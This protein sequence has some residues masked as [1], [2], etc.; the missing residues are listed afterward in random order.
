MKI[1]KRWLI[2]VCLLLV[3]AGLAFAEQDKGAADI[4]LEGGRTGDVPFPHHQH[5]QALKDCDICHQSFAQ[6][7]GAIQKAIADGELKEKQV[8][9]KQCVKCHREKKKAGEKGG[10]ISCS[11]CHSKKK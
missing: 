9:N 6:E 2:L 4:V 8:M 1:G 11:K 7:S 10:P 3:A 5:Q